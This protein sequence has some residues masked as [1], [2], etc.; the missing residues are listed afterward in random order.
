MQNKYVVIS[1]FKYEIQKEFQTTHFKYVQNLNKYF[2]FEIDLF[3]IRTAFPLHLVAYLLHAEALFVHV[4]EVEHGLR[5]M[6]LV[7][8]MPVMRGGHLVINR[9]AIPVIMVIA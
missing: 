5:V 1:Y 4:S 6:L 9:R 3:E 2:V 7:G 8:G